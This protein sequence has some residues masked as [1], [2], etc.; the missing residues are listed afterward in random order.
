MPGQLD[1]AFRS[2][3]QGIY[4]GPPSAKER[5]LILQQ[6]LGKEYSK[7]FS[8]KKCIF[9]SKAMHQFVGRDISNVARK[10]R[11]INARI[12]TQ[13]SH[14]KHLVSSHCYLLHEQYLKI[15]QSMSFRVMAFTRL[16]T[17]KPKMQFQEK[18][19]L[20]QGHTVDYLYLTRMF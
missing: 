15:W 5:G 2:Q 13:A 17:G 1:S 11:G 19:F 7:Q 14:F 20:L 18:I 9:Y 3:S 16:V 8:E 12:I 10:I 6:E 4:I